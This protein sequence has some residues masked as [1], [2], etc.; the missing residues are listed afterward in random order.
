MQRHEFELAMEHAAA[1]YRGTNAHAEI[2]GLALVPLGWEAID[3]AYR[4]GRLDDQLSASR[5]PH[6]AF[7]EML[8]TSRTLRKSVFRLHRLYIARTLREKGAKGLQ[9]VILAMVPLS[10]IRRLQ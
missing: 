7:C 6:Q 3:A 10:A 1:G 5:T 2:L 9:D 8:I 4:G